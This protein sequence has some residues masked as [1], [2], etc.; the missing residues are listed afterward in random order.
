MTDIRKE[1]RFTQ[2]LRKKMI[3]GITQNGE[4]IPTDSKTV[5]LVNEVLV[6]MDQATIAASKLELESEAQKNNGQ[7]AELI[8]QLLKKI[9]SGDP[10]FHVKVETRETP[11]FDT[12]T[13]DPDT[14]PGEMDIDPPQL[15][16]KD[17]VDQA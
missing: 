8:A 11:V 10:T 15:E 3:D 17:F 1:L 16:F 2:D 4:T 13:P 12:T 6:S 9:P 14:V 5:R 7:Q